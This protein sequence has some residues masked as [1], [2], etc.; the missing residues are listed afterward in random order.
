MILVTVSDDRFGRKGGI[1]Q[2]TQEKIERFFKSRPEFGFTDYLMLKWS[3]I[4]GTDFYNNNKNFLTW[5]NPNINGLVY[6][7]F[8]ILEGLNKIKDGD[9]LIY[10]DCSPELWNFEENFY[11]DPNIFDLDVAKKLCEMNNNILTAMNMYLE[12]GLWRG[13]RGFHTHKRMTTPICLKKMNCEKYVDYLQHA[14]GM[15][16]IKK[17]ND[18]VKFIEEWLKWNLVPECAGI[19]D[20]KCD[21]ICKGCIQV[22]CNEHIYRRRCK[23]CGWTVSD[24][25]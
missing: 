3:D 18:T 9:F 14:A 24:D 2:K 15:W 6:K 16:I 21:S 10:N 22:Y 5:M 19:T 11:L 13:G 8:A 23:D 20:L 12:E 4:V 17:N 7:P 1:Y 25:Y